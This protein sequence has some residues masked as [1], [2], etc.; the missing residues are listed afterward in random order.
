MFKCKN[1]SGDLVLDVKGSILKCPYCGGTFPV[2][3]YETMDEVKEQEGFGDD[4]YETTIYT[5]TTCG[6]E[7]AS[8]DSTAVTFCS[9]CG[10][11]AI[12]EGRLSRERKPRFVVPFIKNKEDCKKIYSEKAKKEPYAPKEFTDP[13]FL[14]GFRGIYMPYWELDVGFD[15]EP[16]LKVVDTYTSGNY[17]Y[18]DTYNVQPKLKKLNIPVPRDASSAFDDQIA[19]EIA[20]FH[21]EKMKEFNPAF[22]AGFFTDTA[23][24]DHTVYREQALS[25][26]EDLVISN[27]KKDFRGS[28]T[29][30]LPNDLQKRN[31]LFGT[32]IREAH[33]N[34]FPVWFLTWRKGDRLAYGVIN[35]E[36]GKMSAEIPVDIKKFLMTSGIIALIIFIITNLLSVLVLPHALLQLSACA[37]L[38][39]Q[40]FYAKEI[41]SVRDRE[42][43]AND[44][45]S[46][47]GEAL[48]KAK[49]DFIKGKSKSRNTLLTII[50]SIAAIGSIAI[51]ITSKFSRDSSLAGCFFTFA[52]GVVIYLISLKP[53][54]TV[55]EKRMKLVSLL[56]PVSEFIALYT[57]ATNTIEDWKIYI[58]SALS[59]IV[60]LIVALLMIMDY[61]LL[62]TRSIPEFH[63]RKG[64][65]RDAG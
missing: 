63:N 33:L 21:K 10:T 42:T 65:N 39:I 56:P 25:A 17:D 20:P 31:E 61:N 54:S 43:H 62:T 49:F 57:L 48:K 35:G 4:T 51:G 2:S 7:L 55:R 36:N 1:C 38:I 24:V 13:E 9:Y 6:A 23:D 8:T 32:K 64:G 45:G 3:E 52:G 5:C 16:V 11:Q 37:A 59:M 18:T 47:S 30:T 53:L 46:L 26:A 50:M 29:V 44:I 58:G 19:S 34:L 14:E 41:I 28:A 22:L 27:V 40:C 15:N 12:L 60:C